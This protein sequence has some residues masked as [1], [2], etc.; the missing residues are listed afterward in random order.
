MQDTER[1]DDVADGISLKRLTARGRQ[2]LA[3]FVP[4]AGPAMLAILLS[5]IAGSTVVAGTMPGDEYDAL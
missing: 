3:A 5:D 2:E 1:P 4:D